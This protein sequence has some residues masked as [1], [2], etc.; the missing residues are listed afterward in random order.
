MG[1]YAL[2]RSE[3]RRRV[4]CM[5]TLPFQI[6]FN[7]SAWKWK[8][9]KPKIEIKI[10]ERVF[11]GI[12]LGTSS[13]KVVELRR[14]GDRIKLEN[15]GEMQAFAFY[16]KPFRA[17]Q[18]STLLLSAEDVAK[19]VK[20]VR[21]EAKIKTTEVVFSIPDFS[22]FFTTF[23][24]PAMS[25]EEIPHA[26]EYE[27]RQHVPLP[28]GDIT[29]DWQIV[30]G[31][32]ARDR[33]KG[34][35]LKILLV[36]VPNEVVNQYQKIAEFAQ[37]NLRAIEAEVF[38][39]ARAV[40][41]LEQKPVALVDIGAQTTTVSIVDKNFIK[42]SHSFDMGGNEF[43]QRI[44]QALELEYG[45]AERIKKEQ[46]LEHTLGMQESIPA[47]IA[48]STPR[49]ILTPLID[50]IIVEIEKIS[51]TFKQQTGK[52][53]EKIILGGGSARLPGIVEYI[54]SQLKEQ[55][56]LADPFAPLFYPP[57]LESTLK[58]MGPSWAVAVGAAMRGLE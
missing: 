1:A 49:S 34:T 17:W 11:L 10:P 57:L 8:I 54:G 9:Q 56:V 39:F 36:A 31:K 15:Y 18:K 16:E 25:E 6:P 26:V 33:Q 58:E 24:L 46:G 3:G 30:G 47:A 21:E 7:I 42:L 12:D 32:P 50:L 27:A 51:R 19:A 28:L 41:Q 20:A 44:A 22:T 37:L 4:I 52:E 38:S 43:T 23:E 13:L 35:P 14:V 48:K 55:V 53:V 2:P 29:L 40:A 5:L 45:E